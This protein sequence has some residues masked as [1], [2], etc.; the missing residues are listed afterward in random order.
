MI[1]SGVETDT[2]TRKEDESAKEGD[3]NAVTPPTAPVESV[4]PAPTVAATTPTNKPNDNVA[5]PQTDLSDMNQSVF[6]DDD[7]D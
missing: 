1:Y 3:P 7:L 6:Y 2:F 4:N 5:T